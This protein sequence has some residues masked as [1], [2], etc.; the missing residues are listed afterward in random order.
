MWRRWVVV[1]LAGSLTGCNPFQTGT[2]DDPGDFITYPQPTSA[3]NVLEIIA[4]AMRSRDNLAYLE[5]L[6][7]DFVFHA[8]KLQSQSAAFQSFPEPWTKSH[9]EFFLSALFSNAD[10]VIVDWRNAAVQLRG[11]DADVTVDYSVSVW[12]REQPPTL[13]EGR[14]VIIM[15]QVA[16]I[17]YIHEWSD[18]APTNVTSTWGL[19]RARFLAAG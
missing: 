11:D 6:T 5:R 3:D 13:Y 17:W 2:P 9:E 16:G 7:T 12:G 8:D 10:S 1:A 18:S 15:R 19:L 4:L 14:S